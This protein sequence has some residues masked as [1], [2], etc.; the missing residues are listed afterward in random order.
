MN[1][2]IHRPLFAGKSRNIF[3]EKSNEII[4]PKSEPNECKKSGFCGVSVEKK[5]RQKRRTLRDDSEQRPIEKKTRIVDTRGFP[6][7]KSPRS[8]RRFLRK[9]NPEYYYGTRPSRV[10]DPPCHS[11]LPKRSE[12]YTV[13]EDLTTERP[14]RQPRVLPIENNSDLS[15]GENE[16]PTAPFV[17]TVVKRRIEKNRCV[18]NYIS[19]WSM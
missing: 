19:A 6:E 4:I 2:D 3:R 8:A 9:N 18:D 12:Q 5:I 10:I 17:S 15:D 11:S 13:L 16:I 1:C 14:I 7:P